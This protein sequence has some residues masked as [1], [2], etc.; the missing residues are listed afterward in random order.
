MISK[1]PASLYWY[2]SH[3]NTLQCASTNQFS[4][5]VINFLITGSISLNFIQKFYQTKVVSTISGSYGEDDGG[6]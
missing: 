2:M 1:S 5:D 6:Y 4:M 3:V